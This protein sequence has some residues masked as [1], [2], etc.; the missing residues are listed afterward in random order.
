MTD[1][2]KL[3]LR[4]VIDDAIA[5]FATGRVE[6]EVF[7]KVGFH[8][9]LSFEKDTNCVDGAI[10]AMKCDG[11]HNRSWKCETNIEIRQ[12]KKNGIEFFPAC[13]NKVYSFSA[14]KAIWRYTGCYWNYRTDPKY[15]AN[16]KRVFEFHINII[17]SESG[18]LIADPAM[19]SAPNRRSDV[20]LKIGDKNLHVSKEYLSVLSPVFDALFFGEFVEKRKDEVEI[21]EVVYEE[22]LDLLFLAYND[23]MTITDHT[24]LHILKLVDQFQIENIMKHAKTY[25]TEAKGID[26]MTKLLVADQYNLADLKNHCLKSFTNVT[27]LHKKIQMSPDNGKFSSDMKAAIYDRIAELN[28]E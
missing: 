11:D 23:T 27:A 9:T 25:L 6:S 4:W 16:G 3:V 2:S 24:V 18:E 14:S 22:F 10:I 26:V 1:E 12:Y 7:E 19:F 5:R 28:L 15:I 13:T 17:S 20:I 8:W 21:K